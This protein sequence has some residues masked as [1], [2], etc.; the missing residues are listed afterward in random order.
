MTT[1]TV[2]IDGK[3]VVRDYLE[4]TTMG[5]YIKS[6]NYMDEAIGNFIND[7]DKA[8]LLDNTVIVIYGD[9]DA[10][11]SKQQYDYMYIDFYI[12]YLIPQILNHVH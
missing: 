9:H 11:I 12:H 4:G 3:V 1:K 8:G 2:N 6:V 7:M 5:N 10:R